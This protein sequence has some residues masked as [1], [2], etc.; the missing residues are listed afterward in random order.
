[1][2]K[3]LIIVI[4]FYSFLDA[5][6]EFYY[7][8]VDS[9]GN[10]ISE[11]RKNEINDGFEIIKNVEQL[12][13]EGRVDDAYSLL[14]DFKEKNNLNVL[15]S[16][17]IILYSQL[18]LK[19]GSKRLILD[20]SIELEKAINSSL[21]N[22]YDLS[23]AYSTLV[24]LKLQINKIEDARYFSNVIIDNFDDELTKAYGKVSLA[25]VYKH[26]KDYFKAT[27]VLYEI[28][29]Q[30]KDKLVA[31]IVADELFD[32]YILDN[33]KEKANELIGQ[34]L[35][36]NID[37]YADDSYLATQKINRLIKAGMPEYATEILKELLNR[38][39]KDD[40]IE[41]FK[42]KLA[43]TYMIMYDRTNF[44]LEKAKE[45]FKDIIND[46]PNGAYAKDSKM[47]IDEILMRQG[48][49]KPELVVSKYQGSEEME[50]KALL[51]ELMNYKADKKFD[52]ILKSKKVYKKISNSIAKRFGFSSMD[53]I[54]DEVNI[55]LIKDY[56]I[57]GK[58]FE[59]NN[60][61]KTSRN[62]TLQKLI[63]DETVKYSFFDCMVES[64]NERVYLQLKD[65]FNSSRNAL[66]YLYLE[67]MAYHLNLIDEALDFSAK[68]EM[69]DDEDTLQKE[70]LYRYLI[71]KSKA[72][73]ISL[74][75]FFFYATQNPQYIELNENN[76]L[77]IDIYYDF[78]FYLIKYNEK[79]KSID[80]LKKLYEKQKKLGAYVY[81]PF[82][83]LELSRLQ[84]D[85]N[86]IDKSLEFLLEAL[87]NTRKF[88][89]EDEIKIYYELI[90]I[91]ENFNN[92]QKKEEYI[93]KCKEVDLTI[94][95]LYK[96][97]CQEM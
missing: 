47:Y 20:A 6:K 2:Y 35:R 8:F 80:I 60:V 14:K 10:Q 1:M 87:E 34:V 93:L 54:F 46:Y 77:M 95:N 68:V 91:Y 73:T 22:E 17:I 29:A 64:P 97:M 58:C 23:K 32:V 21:I 41:E 15:K 76:P 90:K 7:G 19:K 16:D 33:Q 94:D 3:I 59:L 85:M 50:Q 37:F 5:K 79:D 75:K 24:E 38:T 55:D 49:V 26:Q 66:I 89:P 96:K 36:N 13:K 27:K 57:S 74:D 62:E 44:Y 9:L 25:K 61:L 53:E 30:T 81:S 88:K 70:F 45:L 18:C 71:L 52:L 31:T 39:T 43:D 42:F 92:I 65:T 72:D 84:K 78:Y 4:F 67:K 83:E 69:V 12:S 48:F 28:L 40:I 63:E 82:V 11:K 56:L 86:N 51:Q